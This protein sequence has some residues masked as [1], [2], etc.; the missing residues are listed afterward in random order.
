MNAIFL[1]VI[2]KDRVMPTGS[3]PPCHV[4]LQR[5]YFELKEKVT[6]EPFIEILTNL[7]MKDNHIK[8]ATLLEQGLLR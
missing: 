5:D 1:S 8:I 3:A 2:L 6:I 7:S 4:Y